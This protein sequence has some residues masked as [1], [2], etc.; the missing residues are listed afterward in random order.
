MYTVLFMKRR[1]INQRGTPVRAAVQWCLLEEVRGSLEQH[2]NDGLRTEVRPLRDAVNRLISKFSALSEMKKKLRYLQKLSDSYEVI[3]SDFMIRS[4]PP[5]MPLNPM[6]RRQTGEM[7]AVGLL[8]ELQSVACT[9]EML[10]FA[11]SWW[12]LAG[13]TVGRTMNVS[14]RQ[15]SLFWKDSLYKVRRTYFHILYLR[16]SS[17][18]PN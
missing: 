6:W 16:L 13:N 1:A 15:G 3:N 2:F 10:P 7:H 18:L 4:V 11:K 17:E 8:L 14:E 5:M 12:P 9:D